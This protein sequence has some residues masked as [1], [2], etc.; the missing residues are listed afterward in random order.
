MK[1]KTPYGKTTQGK[2][3]SL[4]EAEVV[5]RALAQALRGVVDS[6]ARLPTGASALSSR[7]KFSRVLI[8]RI[9]NALKRDEPL[10]T[11]QLLPGP[12]SLRSF[13]QGMG[14]LGV[15]TKRVKAAVGAIDR[16]EMLIRDGFGTRSKLNA[17]ICSHAPSMQSRLEL[18]GRQRVFAGMREL[19]GGEADAWVAAHMLAPDRDDPSK[20]NARI[21]QGFIGLRQL[22]LDTTVYFDFMPAE[23]PSGTQPSSTGKSG[24][25]EFYANPPAR[26]VVEEAQGRKIFRLASGHIGKDFLCD[27]LSL[28]R[29]QGAIARFARSPGRRTG[30][31]ALIKTP[32]KLLHLDILLPGELVD[33][34]E[35][36]LFVFVPGPRNCTNVNDRI[37]D[38]DRVSVPERT[39]VLA[40]GASRFEVPA[41]PNYRRM[42]ERM[43]GEL[44]YDLDAMR[45]HRV[46]VAY[47]PFGYEFVSTFRLHSAP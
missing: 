47:P 28:T 19:R 21:L 33:D 34:S 15:A 12:E 39:E 24:L 43:A 37:D 40:S 46:S 3:S 44:G 29:V 22:R 10:T 45:V 32:V 30:S 31:F 41:V 23:E 38:L 4:S 2:M 8:S 26:L 35:P 36:E 18:G 5:G 11:L 25:E 42:L 27:M 13:V 17:A 9:L 6:S 1:S 20:L 16:F 7:L 14:R